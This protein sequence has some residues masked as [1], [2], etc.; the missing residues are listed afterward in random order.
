MLSRGKKKRRMSGGHTSALSTIHNSYGSTNCFRFEGVIS[1]NP[2]REGTP[3]F[4][5]SV[6]NVSKLFQ[7]TPFHPVFLF[8]L[9]REPSKKTQQRKNLKT[10]CL[11]LFQDVE[12][13]DCSN[14]CH[15]TEVECFERCYL[16]KCHASQGYDFFVDNPVGRCLHQYFFAEP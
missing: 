16:I 14:H 1:A 12:V 2:R 10:Q 15:P 9:S 13:V 8:H 11:R 5:I 3:L 4:S 7:Y 6:A